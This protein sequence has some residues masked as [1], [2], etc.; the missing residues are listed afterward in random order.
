MMK[1]KFGLYIHI[2]FC[3][4]KC[5]YCDFVSFP[6]D[7]AERTEY[8]RLLT[9]ELALWREEIPACEVDTVFIGGGTPSVLDACELSALFQAIWDVFPPE[10]GA[11]FTIECNP[12]TVTEEKLRLMS[13]AGVNRISF[14]LQSAVDSELRALGRIHTYEDFLKSYE[15]ARKT[16]FDNINIDLMSAIPGQTLTSYES[17]LRKVTGLMPEHISSYSLIIEEGT[18][19]YQTYHERPP[20]DEETDRRM[21]ECTGEMLSAAGYKRYE[22]SNYAKDGRMC[23]HNLKYWQRDEYIGAGLSAASLV[24]H[25]RIENEMALDFYRKRILDGELPARE[26]QVLTKEEE[27]AEFMFLGLRCMDGISPTRFQSLFHEDFEARYGK[28]V[29]SLISQGLLKQKPARFPGETLPA[30]DI[31]EAKISERNLCLT[32]RGIDVSNRVFAEFL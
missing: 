25:R 23:L 5:G 20:V 27:M 12:G 28:T 4:R 9:K 13:D 2:P 31:S 18:P 1:N 32:C 10:E 26:T 16:G 22:I 30:G 17:T 7:S 29:Q 15:L 21:Y 11:E 19:F 3:I 8:I 14:G 24:G 6:A